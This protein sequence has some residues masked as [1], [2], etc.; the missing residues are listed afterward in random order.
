MMKQSLKRMRKN[1]GGVGVLLLAIIKRTDNF[2]Q[3]F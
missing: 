1:K 3:L 2:D